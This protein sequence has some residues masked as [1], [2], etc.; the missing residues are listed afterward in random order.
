ME[1]F[2]WICLAGAAGTGARYL[3]GLWAVQRFGPSFPY[4]TLFVNL[5]GCFLMGALMHAALT[6]AWSDTARMAITIGFIGGLTTYS[7]FNYETTRL[8]GTGAYGAALINVS[9]TM[10]GSLVAGVIGAW[11]MRL[12]LSR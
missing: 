10:L 6:M 9:A 5:G 1:R 7:A 3:V 12:L 11:A 8:L 2:A 4:G